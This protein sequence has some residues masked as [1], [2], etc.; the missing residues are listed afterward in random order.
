MIELDIDGEYGISSDK[1]NLILGK[2]IIKINSDGEE[3]ET[4]A[5]RTYHKTFGGLLKKYNERKLKNSRKV[6]TWEDLIRLQK[7]I[8]KTIKGIDK[9]IK[10]KT[11][12]KIKEIE[13]RI[14][15]K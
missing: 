15:G 5:D 6:G 10:G 9:K 1:R 12:K 3:Y 2:Y 7:T 8:H 11:L 4:L 13:D 14:N